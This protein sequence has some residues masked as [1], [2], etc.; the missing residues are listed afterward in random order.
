MPETNTFVEITIYAPSN[1]ADDISTAFTTVAPDNIGNYNLPTYFS[2]SASI[3]G[4]YFADVDFITVSGAGNTGSENLDTSFT[5]ISG[6]PSVVVCLTDFL[7]T[8]TSSGTVGT[9]IDLFTTVSGLVLPS[10]DY[11]FTDFVVGISGISTDENFVV[12]YIYVDKSDYT[13]NY[14]TYYTNRAP[15]NGYDILTTHFFTSVSGALISGTQ[16]TFV[17]VVFSGYPTFSFETSIYSTNQKT[18]YFD[19]ELTIISGGLTRLSTDM[20]STEQATSYLNF[21]TI[22]GLTGSG[23]LDTETTVISGGLHAYETDIFST[24]L[25]LAELASTKTTLTCDV[26]LFPIKIFNFSIDIGEYLTS[27]GTISVDIT[28]DL[29]NIVTSGTNFSV[30]GS[31]VPVTF[32]GIANGYRMYYNHDFSDLTGPAVITAHAENDNGNILELWLFS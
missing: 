15:Q 7:T 9:Y 16:P 30:N 19:S 18:K 24:Y 32:S 29:Y 8:V 14:W 10:E 28:D 4:T 12:D 11:I 6:L 26:G 2:T 20:Y 1:G 3:S 22:C 31:T 27:S 21:E 17:D 25:S 23:I 5:T 13:N